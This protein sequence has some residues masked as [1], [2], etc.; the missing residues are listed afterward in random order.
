VGVWYLLLL[1]LLLPEWLHLMVGFVVQRPGLL[2]AVA[3]IGGKQT[4]AD[5]LE[6]SESISAAVEHGFRRYVLVCY[7]NV[8]LHWV[9]Q[10]MRR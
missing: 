9:L 5:A 1:L 2:Q 3:N 7:A 10:S 4:I 6:A 8:P